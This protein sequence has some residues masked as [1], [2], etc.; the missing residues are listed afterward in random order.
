MEEFMD[1]IINIA[2]QSEMTE[3][4]VARAVRDAGPEF[5]LEVP[6]P[7]VN[8]SQS[9]LDP[10]LDYLHALYIGEALCPLCDSISHEW[11]ER[12]V[13]LYDSRR[14]PVSSHFLVRPRDH[15]VFAKKLLELA[16]WFEPE[17][18]VLDMEKTE[19]LSEYQD[20]V[21]ELSAA[22]GIHFADLLAA[23]V[24]AYQIAEGEDDDEDDLE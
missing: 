17:D 6:L 9:Y 3:A 11:F 2:D 19:T 4:E 15:D 10:A 7:S 24:E 20:T 14:P 16:L 18:D 22:G 8:H 5:V 1:N 23:Y 21:E 12:D 13:R